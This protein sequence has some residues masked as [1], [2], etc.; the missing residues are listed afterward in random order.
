MFRRNRSEAVYVGY[1]RFFKGFLLFGM[2]AVISLFI[3]FNQSIVAGL[4]EDSARISQ[5]YAR[6]IQFG[7]SEAT[8]PGVIDFIFENIITKV[9]F[10]IIVTDKYGNPAAWTGDIEPVDT[11]LVSRNK[12]LEY[13]K[14]FDEQNPPIQI[15]S[16]GE[17]ISILHYGDSRLIKQLQLIPVVEISVVGVFILVAFVGIRHIQQ[18]E[19][20]SIWVGMA[21]ETAHQLGTP[22]SSL[23][24]WVELMKLK[25]NEGV[26]NIRD[27]TKECDFEDMTSRMLN[28]LKRLDRIATRFGQI[29]SIP[30]LE[31]HDLNAIVD[32][33]VG[34]F[35]LRIPSSG[36]AITAKY[37]ELPRAKVN[38]ELMS[39]VIE[40]LVKNSL[41]ATN[42]RTGFIKLTTGIDESGRKII[43]TVEDNGRGIPPSEHKKIFAPGFTTKKRG[44]GLGLTLARRIV[45]EYHGGRIYLRSS[46]PG[47]KTIFAVEIPV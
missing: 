1:S 46:E 25:F 6:L 5:A 42:P 8:D 2:V 16:E 39:W 27:G 33:T 12:L 22:L 32:E 28:D 17:V 15:T 14:E 29:G 11:T 31:K 26:I 24:G 30:E 44:W 20:R 41:E 23:I 45:E 13:I 19:Q 47:I 36:L 38:V 10:P 34:Y 3:F 18:S 21:K 40:N 7:A 35:K 9:N 37:G 4:R 43:I